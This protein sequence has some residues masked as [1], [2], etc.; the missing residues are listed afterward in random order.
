MSCPHCGS[1]P[2]HIPYSAAPQSLR[3]CLACG[4]QFHEPAEPAEPEPCTPTPAERLDRLRRVLHPRLLD[5]DPEE[6][7]TVYRSDL[8]WLVSAY[9]ALKARA[10]K[11]E[12]THEIDH[13]LLCDWVNSLPEPFRTY[14]YRIETDA[15]PTDNIRDAVCWKENA[16]ALAAR[17]AELEENLETALSSHRKQADRIAELL[18]QP[19]DALREW[20]A[21]ATPEL[22]QDIRDFLNGRELEAACCERVWDERNRL[23]EGYRSE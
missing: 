9:A 4:V 23:K 20:C 21:V 3:V 17:V 8:A 19:T 15:N 13:K 11:M 2:C 14:V 18:R 22:A 6:I 10:D 12:S 5:P 1:G 16:N 7:G